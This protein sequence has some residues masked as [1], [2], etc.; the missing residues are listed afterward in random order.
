MLYRR[1]RR[2]GGE[3]VIDPEVREQK[4]EQPGREGNRHN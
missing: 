3:V 1:P 2:R 4:E